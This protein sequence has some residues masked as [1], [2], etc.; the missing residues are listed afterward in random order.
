MFAGRGNLRIRTKLFI[1]YFSVFVLMLAG[2]SILTYSLVKRSIDANISNQMNSALD[3]I[4]GMVVETADLVIRHHLRAIVEKRVEA[5]GLHRDN[6][7]RGYVTEAVAKARAFKELTSETIG[8]SGY[9]YCLDSQGIIKAHPKPSLVGTDVSFRAFVKEQLKSGSGYLEYEWQNPF[10]SSPRL[11]ALYMKRFEPWDLIVS[12][13]SYKEEFS[14]LV[15]PGELSKAVSSFRFGRSGHTFI[16]DQKGKVTI[17]SGL[18][19]LLMKS[20]PM[21][22]IFATPKGFTLAQAGNRQVIHAHR[23]IPALGWIIVSSAYVDEFDTASTQIQQAFYRTGLVA[24]FV[25]FFVVLWLS[26]NLNRPVKGMIHTFGRGISGD[27]SVRMK[28]TS[29]TYEFKLLARH[30]NRFMETFENYA[31]ELNTKILELKQSKERIRVLAK[32]PDENPNPVLRVSLDFTLLYLNQTAQSLFSDR[33]FEEGK[34]LPLHWIQ[35]LEQSLGKASHQELEITLDNRVFFFKTSNISDMASFY[36]YGREITEKKHYENLLLLSDSVF[37]NSIEGITVSDADGIIQRVNPAFEG[38]TGYSAK[39]AVG[40]NPRILKSDRHSPEFYDKMWSSLKEKGQWSGEIWNRKKN[41][42]A[43]PEWLSITAIMGNKGDVSSYVAVFH[44]MT[45]IRRSQE[46]LKFKTYHDGLTGLP[47]RLL[48]EDRLERSIG[49]AQ[50]NQRLVAV[51]CLDLDNFKHVN[52]SLGHNIGDL[53][54]KAVGE[55]LSRSFT[56]K[57]TVSRFGGDQFNIIL[58]SINTAKEAVTSATDLMAL[59]ESPFMVEEKEI[60]ANISIGISL[61]PA[62]G[63]TP[64][65]LIQNAEIAMHKIKASGKNSYSLFETG[66]NQQMIKR[67]ELEADLR[68]GLQKNEFKLFYQPKVAVETGEIS[69]MEA[70]I[71]WDNGEKG[72]ISPGDF[73][74]IAEETG[75]IEPIGTW[76]LNQACIQTKKWHDLGFGSLKIAVNL[77]AVQFRNT[78]LAS[79]VQAALNGA[80]LEPRFLNLEIT[81]SLVMNDVETAIDTMNR[82]ADL[83]VSFSIDDF[84][85]GYSSLS[86]LKRFPV[87]ILKVDQSFVREIPNSKD[88]MVIARTILSMAKSLNMKTV[89]EGVETKEQL[90]F[91]RENHCDEIQGY[92]FSPPVPADKFQALLEGGMKNA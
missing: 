47:N 82:I 85:T 60:Y 72:L 28:E 11:K 42:E 30:F 17:P 45:E 81:E 22:R 91:M 58:N 3:S 63:T 65:A 8:T 70:L 41:G 23:Q 67:I 5:L 12:A 31:L 43:Y 89:A 21:E 24:F 57:T 48:F 78:E 52:E 61:Y 88:D 59:F 38:I 76:V 50:K 44:D 54:L 16:M 90:E 62:D 25:I 6:V 53:F 64:S 36:V 79:K 32:F 75:V 15:G 35:K 87:A 20:V 46:K 69:G 51:L 77:S 14:D 80:G 66:M 86:Y 68:H 27:F 13:S 83:G 49:I 84:G 33:G 73:I 26:N 74:P 7:R 37:E 18:D 9:L 4:Q 29:D 55:R 2:S 1:T 19:P 39:E 56:D 71:R 10:D 40:Q 92:Y 34:P